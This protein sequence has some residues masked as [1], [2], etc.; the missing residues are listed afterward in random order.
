MPECHRCK[1]NGTGEP[2]A[3]ADVVRVL[4]QID[5]AG[6]TGKGGWIEA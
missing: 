5:E 3:L 6:K 1:F 4:Q 2:W